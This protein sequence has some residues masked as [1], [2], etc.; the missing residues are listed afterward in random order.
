MPTAAMATKYLDLRAEHEGCMGAR[1]GVVGSSEPE[2]RFVHDRKLRW[3]EHLVQTVSLGVLYIWRGLRQD[4]AA[5][6]L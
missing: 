5:L 3:Q 2:R 1:V 4:Q 6:T